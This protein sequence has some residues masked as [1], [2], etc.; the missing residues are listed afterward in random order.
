MKSQ[1]SV[2]LAVPS[3]ILPSETN[4]LLNPAYSDFSKIKIAT[5]ESFVFDLRLRD[6]W[7]T[8]F[9]SMPVTKEGIE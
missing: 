1:C 8:F 7:D 5:P 2:I 4:Y 6:T 3:V 9:L